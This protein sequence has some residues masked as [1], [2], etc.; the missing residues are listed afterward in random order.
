MPVL[1]WAPNQAF[2]PTGIELDH[3]I[4]RCH[5]TAPVDNLRQR[6]PHPRHYENPQK[7]HRV[8]RHAEIPATMVLGVARCVAA[9]GLPNVSSPR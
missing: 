4:E 8:E 1:T 2:K 9:S 6:Y 7:R 5:V 3:P